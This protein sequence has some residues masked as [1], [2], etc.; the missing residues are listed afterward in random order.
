M[1]SRDYEQFQAKAA[2][3]SKFKQQRRD[4]SPWNS[5][6]GVNIDFKDDNDSPIKIN[7]RNELRESGLFEA[8]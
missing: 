8:N 4:K 5:N 1:V 2:S 6:I 7:S 3:P